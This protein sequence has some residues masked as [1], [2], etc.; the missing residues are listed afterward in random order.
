MEYLIRKTECQRLKAIFN[1]IVPSINQGLVK[2]DVENIE[3]IVAISLPKLRDR[4]MDLSSRCIKD[5]G[6]EDACPYCDPKYIEMFFHT[7]IAE[8]Q[9]GTR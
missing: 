7:M 4:A 2:R 3:E 5:S 8:V 6:C 9:N 1:N